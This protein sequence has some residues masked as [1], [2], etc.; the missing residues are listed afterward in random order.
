MLR[1]FGVGLRISLSCGAVGM[2]I[3]LI[4]A[5]GVDGDF[6]PAMHLF[7]ATVVGTSL[8]LGIAVVC[9]TLA[10]LHALLLSLA[11]EIR[12]IL[13]VMRGETPA[14][15]VHSSWSPLWDRDLDG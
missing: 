11:S 1:A 4:T 5:L 9:V 2:V 12:L 14:D 13:N 7:V 10:A 8:G 6:H 15:H 3:G